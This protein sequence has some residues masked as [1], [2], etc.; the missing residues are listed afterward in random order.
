MADEEERLVRVAREA[1]VGD[2]PTVLGQWREA[3]GVVRSDTTIAVLTEAHGPLAERGHMDFGVALNLE[4]PDAPVIWDCAAGAGATPDD[5]IRDA[6]HRWTLGTFAVFAELLIQDGSRADHFR[7]R[8]PGGVPGWHAIC[9]PYLITGSDEEAA[10]EL[11][12]WL[13]ENPVLPV[14]GGA[15][16]LSMDA[17]LGVHGVK[18]TIGTGPDQE[19]VEVRVDG[20]EDST[21]T[22]RIADLAWPR[23]GRSFLSLRM[24]ALLIPEIDEP[25]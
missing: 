9:G 5:R 7:S 16:A 13:N 23:S 1:L 11:L 4:N 19:F 22:Q 6:V 18:L 20:R 3:D 17:G 12:Q 21:V 24:F 25:A 10:S 8:E 14:L 15:L 2:L